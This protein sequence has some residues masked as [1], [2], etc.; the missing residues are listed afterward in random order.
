VDKAGYIYQPDL[1][2]VQGLPPILSSI[3]KS[4]DSSKEL[5][6]GQTGLSLS[7]PVP[8]NSGDTSP[9]A[10][11]TDY[12]AACIIAMSR[13]GHYRYIVQPKRHAAVFPPSHGNREARAALLI[14]ATLRWRRRRDFLEYVDGY[15]Y[16]I[17]EETR[18]KKNTNTEQLRKD[19]DENTKAVEADFDDALGYR[20]IFGHLVV[21]KSQALTYIYNSI[22]PLS[23][24]IWIILLWLMDGH[25]TDSRTA[26]RQVTVSSTECRSY[27][28]LKENEICSRE[29]N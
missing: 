4:I 29:S 24:T 12:M 11:S 15:S 2:V 22:R 23:A 10:S 16:L 17:V 6:R 27:T 26:L 19:R 9:K 5:Y 8:G 13:G 1:F 25:R 3:L 21:I 18:A 7:V 28:E 20:D 14:H